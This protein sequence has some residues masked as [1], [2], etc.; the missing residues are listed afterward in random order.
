[1][2][3]LKCAVEIADATKTHDDCLVLTALTCDDAKPR[4]ALVGQASGVSLTL[5]LCELLAATSFI[6]LFRFTQIAG[7]VSI[8]LFL[9]QYSCARSELR[10]LLWTRS[11]LT[12]LEAL[13]V[14]NTRCFGS[15][16]P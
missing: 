4:G 2:G 12:N 14:H 3:V 1:M 11:F 9:R 16:P 7:S 10:A 6:Q 8:N 15:G 13:I 5:C